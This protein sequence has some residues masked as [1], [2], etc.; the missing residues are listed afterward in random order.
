LEGTTPEKATQTPPVSG[1]KPKS[2]TR[3]IA[4]VGVIVVILIVLLAVILQGL[5]NNAP[6][7]TFTIVSHGVAVEPD[8]ITAD[9]FD[10]T[11]SFMVNNTG[12]VTGNVTVIF[13]VISGR[14]TWAGAQIF[15]DVPPGK[16]F[17]SYKKHIPVEGNVTSDWVY[18]VYLSGQIMP[19]RYPHP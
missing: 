8:S 6:K 4:I 16:L 2:K 7:P 12:T 15:K 9:G 13:K 5:G 19:P 1:K 3:R 14:Y 17:S 11:V 18:Q 10:V